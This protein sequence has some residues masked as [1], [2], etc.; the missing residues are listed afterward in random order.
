MYYCLKKN[1]T[2]I[3]FLLI[4]IKFRMFQGK[5]KFGVQTIVIYVWKLN[6]DV[7]VAREVYIYF[8]IRSRVCYSLA[9]HLKA[10]MRDSIL[11]YRSI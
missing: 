2:H 4:M 7:E 8:L 9:T 1:V 6:M 10:N 3:I 11:Y 5:A